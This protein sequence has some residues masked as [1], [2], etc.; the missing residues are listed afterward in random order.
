[1]YYNMYYLIKTL[2][3]AFLRRNMFKFGIN[4]VFYYNNKSSLAKR[5]R[6]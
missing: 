1:M 5:I 3:G 4:F 6:N 2:T